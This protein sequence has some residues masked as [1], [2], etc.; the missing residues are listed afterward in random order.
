[1][2]YQKC[3]SWPVASTLVP[4][5]RWHIHLCKSRNSLKLTFHL[6]KILYGT[7]QCGASWPN[8]KLM[9]EHLTRQQSVA[10]H[11]LMSVGLGFA[12]IPKIAGHVAYS[13]EKPML[14]FK[15]HGP[16]V[17]YGPQFPDSSGIMK[18][19]M[20]FRLQVSVGVEV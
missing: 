18:H 11:Y 10:H 14:F 5:P 12:N 13:F 3:H 6:L 8:F 4:N 15:T 19:E 2:R 7:K 1:M 9:G 17:N 16:E 20:M